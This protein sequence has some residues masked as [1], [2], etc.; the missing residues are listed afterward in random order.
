MTLKHFIATGVGIAALVT[1]ASSALAAPIVDLYN[2][3]VTDAGTVQAN[4]AS[5]LHYAL[6]A[7]PDPIVGLRVATS[8][9]GFPIPPWIGDNATSAWIGPVG[10]QALDGSVG[11]YTYLTTFT[12][13]NVDPATAKISGQWSVDNRGLDILLNGRSL[14]ITNDNAFTSFT[15]FTISSGFV[16]GLNTL[17]FVVLNESGPTGLRVEMTGTAGAVPEPATWAM[18]VLGFGVVGAGMRRKQAVRVTYA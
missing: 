10:D 13:N 16:S 14:G 5:A 12:L 15:P 8:D 18:M 6:T 9:N 1:G 17:E 3:G 4:G 7:S 11:S 2:T